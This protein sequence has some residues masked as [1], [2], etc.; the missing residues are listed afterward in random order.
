M[1]F[2]TDFGPVQFD[3]PEAPG[4]TTVEASNGAE[5]ECRWEFKRNIRPWSR[6]LYIGV[7]RHFLS[8]GDT[9][10]IRFGDRSQGSRGVRLQT[11]CE[12]EFEFRVFVD[13]IATYDY[14]ALSS[15]PKIQI[16]P[17]PPVNWRATL[18]TLRRPKQDFRLSVKAE[19][20]WG[21]P[22]NL[23]RRKLTLKPNFPVQGLPASVEFR[24]GSFANIIENLSC[25]ETGDLVVKIFDET[26]TELCETNPLRI[27]DNVAEV[28]FWADLH[29]QSNETLGTNTAREYFMFGRDRAFLDACAHQGNDF[30]ITREFWS[31]LNN[32][33]S[34]FDEPG[35]FVCIPGYEW[36][37][38]TSVGGDRNVFYRQEGRPIF[39]SSHAQIPDMIDEQLDAHNA[40]ELFERLSGE[41]CVCWAHCGGRYADIK[42]AHNAK[43]KTAIEIHSSWGTFEWL[44]ADAFEMNY[45]IGIVANSDGHKGRVGASYPGASFFGSFGGLTCFLAPEL[46]R[47][48]IFEAMRRRHHFA[49]T[50]ARLLLDTSAEFKTDAKLYS[51]DPQLGPTDSAASQK[52][53]MG[54]IAGTAEKAFDFLVE[55]NGSAPIERV[56]IF[57]GPEHLETIKPFKPGELGSRIRIIYRGAEYRGRAR[58][59]NWDGNLSI[60]DNK[61]IRA[62][63]FNNWNLDRTLIKHDDQSLSWK[64]VTTGNF[65]GI[66]IW[67][68]RKEQGSIRI[69]TEHTNIDLNISDIGFGD[70]IFDAGGLDRAINVFRLP[71][72]LIQTNMSITKKIAVR[73]TGDTRPFA[74]ITQ[75]D[76][77]RA[78]SSPI[79]IFTDG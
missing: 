77:H 42:Y 32:L 41:N 35:R 73:A 49:T 1:R 75:I 65:G 68:E 71:D 72:Q 3:S 58:T 46:T 52:L 30:Q 20:E 50:G 59:T 48:A 66:D 16:V 54:D 37:A 27:S 57:D 25:N 14:V 70:L 63:M 23:I 19:D 34:E 60:T 43:L 51:R 79:Y 17:G 2:A 28:H 38:N 18:P 31:E 62:K 36:S 40:S 6:S 47:E 22:S 44:L 61:I 53:M 74:R 78:W 5:L 69:D 45:R 76:G 12:T 7:K 64:A 26:G 55:V 21:N 67:L 33:T 8:E 39:R 24:E 9:I 4:Y 15:S 11:Y 10:T 29:G 13:A 56:D